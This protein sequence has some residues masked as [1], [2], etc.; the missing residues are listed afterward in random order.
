MIDDIIQDLINRHNKLKKNTF[1]TADI[2]MVDDIILSSP[3][4]SLG[5]ILM[6]FT[7]I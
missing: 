6:T 3:R 7:S 5:C 1:P 2:D 4:K